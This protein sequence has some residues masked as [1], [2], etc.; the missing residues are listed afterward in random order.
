[1]LL[2][3]TI[4]EALGTEFVFARLSFKVPDDAFVGLPRIDNSF[5]SKRLKQSLM[6]LGYI[7]GDSFNTGFD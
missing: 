1:M 5:A 6:Q 7:D 4:P 2:D 3:L